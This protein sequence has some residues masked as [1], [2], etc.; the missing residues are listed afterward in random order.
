MRPFTSI[1]I[2]YYL[3]CLPNIKRTNSFKNQQFAHPITRLQTFSKQP[4]HTNKATAIC[5]CSHIP[6]EGAHNGSRTRDPLIRRRP[7]SAVI[8]L[9]VSYMYCIGK[10][11]LDLMVLMSI[12]KPITEISSNN[13]RLLLTF[14]ERLNF[15]LTDFD[16]ILETFHTATFCSCD[17]VAIQSVY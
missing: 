17:A 13:F 6:S 4:L 14:I 9:S 12:V 1:P 3:T 10:S 15:D 7:D 11:V 16:E 2:K 8:S 5:L